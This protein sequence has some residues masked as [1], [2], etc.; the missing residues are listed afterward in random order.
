MSA[1][2]RMG[3]VIC[4]WAGGSPGKLGVH[5]LAEQ[6]RTLDQV[7]PVEIIDRI[8]SPVGQE[9]LGALF[10][11]GEADR[12]VIVACSAFSKET[13]FR[14]LARASGINPYMVELADV[15]EQSA[16]VHDPQ[17]AL[18][19]AHLIMEMAVA[20]S[21]LA[22]E[23]PVQVRQ[24]RSKRALIIGDGACALIAA[25]HLRE[26]G[27]E[28]ALVTE[29]SGFRIPDRLAKQR[30]AFERDIDL[31]SHDPGFVIHAQSRVIHLAGRL[32]DFSMSMSSGQSTQVVT[33]GAIVLA[34]E[35]LEGDSQTG[36]PGDV[37]ELESV[38]AGKGVLP[39]SIVVL[40]EAGQEWGADAGAFV[41]GMRAAMN[42]KMKRPKAKAYVISR[43]IVS[44]GKWESEQRM[45]QDLGIIFFRSNE[46]PKMVDAK[47]WALKDQT[48]GDIVIEAEAA[49]TTRHPKYDPEGIARVLGVPVGPDGTPV[50]LEPRLRPE[51][52]MRRGIFL[53]SSS[54]EPSPM[55]TIFT[56]ALSVTS[57]VAEA[58]LG[59]ELLGGVVT[60]VDQ[61]KCSACL[62]C[63]R[64]CP[65]SAPF[66]GDK[67]KAEIPIEDCQGCGICVSL[68]P[69][70]AIDLYHYG[71]SQIGA[72]V[73]VA[74]RG[75]AQ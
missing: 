57:R 68:C 43:D 51:E 30:E 15:R 49:Y 54:F 75:G 62:T 61:E 31:L 3:V 36:P 13:L 4:A 39:E 40:A 29:G 74:V 63:V 66:I 23:A 58:L 26:Q 19:K 35:A 60:R 10:R 52:T 71:D 27:I 5:S 38:L 65:Y 32:G 28:V 21:R 8:C 18:E 6:A 44:P 25:K 42:F 55:E 33:C 24:S 56:D 41:R 70:K 59:H 72:S 1:R 22:Q 45:A 48:L 50:T 53:C 7:G 34:C 2:G 67:G 17:K 46:R 47:H 9:K 14:E 20:R 11:S 73:R 12:F 16:Y 37:S 69:S 64:S